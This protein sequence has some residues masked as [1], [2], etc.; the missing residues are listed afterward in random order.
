MVLKSFLVYALLSVAVLA[1]SAAGV[2]RPP[3][4]GILFN[5]DGNQRFMWD[6]AGA[7]KP[8]R[9]DQLVDALANSQVTTM[10]ID[11]CSQTTTHDT[12]APGWSTFTTTRP[13]MS[14]IVETTSK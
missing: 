14:A 4:R 13:T 12:K 11:C 5:E 9:L 2:S 3:I 6:P 1:A 7:I 10:L 8:E